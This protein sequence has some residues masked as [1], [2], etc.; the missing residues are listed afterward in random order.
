VVLSAALW[1]ASATA[2]AHA[3]D[4]SVPI[5]GRYTAFSDG[6]WAQT[7]YRFH[8]EPPVTS[9]WTIT[10]SCTTYLDCSGNV[11]SDLGWS[12]PVTCGAGVWK[13]NRHLPDWEPC[14]DRTSAPG[15]QQYLFR[16]VPGPEV[17]EGWDT[18]T[19]ISGA[20]GINQWLNISM[21]FKLTKIE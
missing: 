9:T 12:A 13:V 11:A 4:C 14:A 5:S 6:V 7:N 15:R 8:D 19:G 2:P 17:F 21:P 16:P 3:G 18:T 10:S 20:C 1:T